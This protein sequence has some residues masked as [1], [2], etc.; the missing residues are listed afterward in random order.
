MVKV[1]VSSGSFG[2][3]LGISSLFLPNTSNLDS[4]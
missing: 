2:L 1:L 4:I 3:L